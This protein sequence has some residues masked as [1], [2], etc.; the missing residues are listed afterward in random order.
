[1]TDSAEQLFEQ[2]R[3]AY[4]GTDGSR[5]LNKAFDLCRQAHEE[6]NFEATR[7]LATFY[8]DGVEVEQDENRALELYKEAV[9]GGFA[10]AFY[11]MGNLFFKRQEFQQALDHWAHGA[12]CGDGYCVVSL[13][14]CFEEG[15]IV[16]QDLAEAVRLYEHA[17]KAENPEG[18]I[19]L[20]LCYRDGLGVEADA[21]KMNELLEAAKSQNHPFAWY[22][23]G[24][25]QLSGEESADEVKQSPAMPYFKK[26][27]ELGQVE[28]MEVCGEVLCLSQNPD[29]V[30]G[31][32]FL[33]AAVAAESPRAKSILAILLASGK[34]CPVDFEK[35]RDLCEQAASHGDS[36]AMRMLGLMYERGDGIEADPETALEWFR[37][38]A[39]NGDQFSAQK[40][41]QT[42]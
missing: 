22:E 30:T 31:R 9:E 40:L 38:A 28:A 20:A 41:Q 32:A 4:L 15:R 10:H 6:G 18:Q 34:G 35:A 1:M 16:E 19:R 42:E 24:R 37:R 36:N 5:D 29:Y 14:L 7:M 23:L 12:E 17:A 21:L 13:G 8:E 11:N 3:K 25:Q 39:A 27:A 26:A 33:D 2:A